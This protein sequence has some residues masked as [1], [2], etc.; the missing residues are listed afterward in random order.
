M[1]N[2]KYFQ[3]TT[4]R[5]YDKCALKRKKKQKKPSKKIFDGYVRL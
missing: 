1:S 4:T 3:S 5:V 2:A